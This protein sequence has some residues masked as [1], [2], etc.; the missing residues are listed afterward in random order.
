[1][2]NANYSGY[3]GFHSKLNT[4]KRM[5]PSE[6]RDSS[7]STFLKDLKELPPL[8]PSEVETVLRKKDAGLRNV[9]QKVEPIFPPPPDPS[10][11][12]TPRTSAPTL[13]KSCS[14]GTHRLRKGAQLFNQAEHANSKYSTPTTSGVTNFGPA[15][16][17]GTLPVPSIH[18]EPY[19]YVDFQTKY[20]PSCYPSMSSGYDQFTLPRFPN[21]YGNFSPYAR[22]PGYSAWA[23]LGKYDQSVPNR[24]SQNPITA[25]M[26]GTSNYGSYLTTTAPGNPGGFTTNLPF[27]NSFQN[28]NFIQN[29]QSYTSSVDSQQPAYGMNLSTYNYPQ[30]SVPPNTTSY[31]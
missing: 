11:T 10:C 8:H 29:I 26:S 25:S 17:Q 2:F 1:M 14:S 24:I 16:R 15:T 9:S 30:P 3:S 13:N 5:N 31:L 27:N 23:S 22:S 4:V 20:D 6:F 7:D 19:P 21:D 12:V 28:E 18:S